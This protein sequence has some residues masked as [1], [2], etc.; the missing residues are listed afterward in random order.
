MM[1]SLNQLKITSFNCQGFKY[2]NYD[3]LKDIFN[4]SDILMLQETWLYNFEHTMF[5]N[6]LPLSQSHAVSAMDEAEIGRRGRPY[7]GCSIVWHNNLNLSIEPLK[8]LSTRICAAHI[9]GEN[10]NCIIASIYMPSD[11]NNNDNCETFGDVLYELSTLIALYDDCDIIIGGDFNVDFD[12]ALSRNLNIFKHFMNDEELLC[13]SIHV[14]ANNFTR[15]DIH[16]NRSFIDHFLL[17]E[18]II[19][20]NFNIAYDGNNLSDHKPITIKITYNTNLLEIL[21]SKCKVMNWSKASKTSIKNYQTLV[22]QHLKEFKIPVKVKKCNIPLCKSHDEIIIEKLD[23]LM[24]ILIM[25]AH[26]TIPV[27]TINSKKGIPGWNNYVKPYKDKSIFWN[28]IWKSAG[29]PIVGQLADLRKFTRAKYHWAIKQVKREKDNIILH[30]TAQQ[31]ASKSFREFWITMKKLNGNKNVIAKIVDNK[32]NDDEITGLFCS[33]YKELYNSVSD[34]NFKDTV[35]AVELLVKNKCNKNLCNLPNNHNVSA[36]I[37]RNAI[38][39]LKRGKDDEIFEMYS[40]HFINAPKSA[41]AALG[42]IIT[43]MLSHG[44]TNQIINKSI[45]KPI[46]KNKQKSLSDSNNY[47]AI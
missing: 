25:C 36:T 24:D 2:R 39:N 37:V 32:N 27:H 5:N 14:T 30:N 6:V 26:D 1:G 44:T 29:K 20:N 3:Y 13:P 11:D 9:K 8:M 45:I 41:H 46:P 12:R 16:G 38:N 18:N 28:D 17:S 7:G 35:N 23:E 22:D 15:E 34:K 47:R 43:L 19:H 33:K 21:E 31:L 42:Q 10:I 40:D 4:K